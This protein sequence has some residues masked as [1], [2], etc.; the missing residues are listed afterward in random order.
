MKY[1]ELKEELDK[2]RNQIHFLQEKVNDA[3]QDAQFR[4]EEVC[5]LFFK[6]NPTHKY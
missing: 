6:F 1:E 2:A 3:E 4:A 5:S